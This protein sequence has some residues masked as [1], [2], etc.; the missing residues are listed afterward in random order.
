MAPSSAIAAIHFMIDLAGGKAV[1]HSLLYASSYKRAK[2]D[3]EGGS[4]SDPAGDHYRGRL[5]RGREFPP[6]GGGAQERLRDWGGVRGRVREIGGGE[7]CRRFEK[8]TR[9][10]ARGR[11]IREHLCYP[12]EPRRDGVGAAA[13]VDAGA[14][15][16]RAVS[17]SDLGWVAGSGKCGDHRAGGGGFRGHRRGVFEG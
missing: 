9:D 14:T 10:G 7:A 11:A 12:S 13:G 5:C 15:I 8:D 3:A 1:N 16:S 6:V 17:G 4:E 2:P